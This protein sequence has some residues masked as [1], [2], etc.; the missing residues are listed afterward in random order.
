MIGSDSLFDRHKFTPIWAGCCFGV[1]VY[2]MA[3]SDSL[4]AEILVMLESGFEIIWPN[5]VGIFL[6]FI[7]AV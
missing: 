7:A 5:C 4:G 6:Y 1:V 2:V 3:V